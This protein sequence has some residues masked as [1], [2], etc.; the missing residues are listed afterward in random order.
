VFSSCTSYK[1]D[2]V[3]FRKQ[4]ENNEYRIPGSL[5]EGSGEYKPVG[6]KWEVGIISLE[7]CGGEQ[8]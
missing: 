1:G 7:P 4:L 3:K 8:V 2:Y 5:A 6:K